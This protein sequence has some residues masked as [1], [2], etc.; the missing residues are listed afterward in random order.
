VN[1]TVFWDEDDKKRNMEAVG[2]SEMTHKIVMYITVE[3]KF[4]TGRHLV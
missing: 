1:V 3:F 4:S 2:F